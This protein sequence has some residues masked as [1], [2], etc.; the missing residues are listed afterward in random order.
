L[1]AQNG[2]IVKMSLLQPSDS[3][4][5]LWH[6]LYGSVFDVLWYRVMVDYRS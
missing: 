2:I 1:K 6:H 5:F 3:F 4:Y